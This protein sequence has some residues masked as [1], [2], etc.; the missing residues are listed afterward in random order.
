MH[1]QQPVVH[2]A[3]YGGQGQQDGEEGEAAHR[4]SITAHLVACRDDPSSTG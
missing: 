4:D 2:D 3:E 1:A